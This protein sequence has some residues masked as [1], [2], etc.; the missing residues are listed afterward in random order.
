MI[1]KRNF[2]LLIASAIVFAAIAAASGQSGRRATPGST[3]TVAPSI[4]GPKTV[5]TKP[6][7][8]P[9]VQLL[10]GINSRTVFTSMPYYIYDTVLDNCLRRLG[11]AEI[12]F[13][14]SGGNA[15]NRSDAIKAAKQETVRYVV[16]LEVGS[17]FADSGRQA[18]NGQD[19]LYVS[20]TI[21]EPQTAKVKRSGRTH[22]LIY[23]TGRGGVSLPSRN[24]A[25]YSEYALK[26]AARETADRILDAFDIR[27]REKPYE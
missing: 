25:I 17:E 2:R 7:P 12:V 22:Q 11:E 8:Q 9:K 1:L 23:Q 26:Q 3:P 10:V 27:V 14:I 16:L 20:Y 15:M 6:T 13:P 18:R 21:F 5:E 24:G 19:E 4:S